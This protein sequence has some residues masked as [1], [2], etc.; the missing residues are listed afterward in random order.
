MLNLKKYFQLALIIFLIVA[1]PRQLFAGSIKGKLQQRLNEESNIQY[2]PYY[3]D[4]NAA[5]NQR[6]EMPMTNV[7]TTRNRIDQS[8]QVM[9]DVVQEV[10]MPNDPYQPALSPFAIYNMNYTAELDENVV[11]VKGK[12]IFE[13]FKKEGWTQ[14]PIVNNSVGLIDVR[15]NKG[16]SF[17][18]NQNG[19]YYLMIDKPGRYNLD[20]EYLI[21]AKREREFGPG[22]FIVDVMPAP[23]SQ[24]EF[25]IPEKSVQVFIEPAIKVEL[26][27]EE[28][29]TIA[30]AVMPNTS[31]ISVRWT[32]AL[33]REEIVPI[34]LEPKAY[35]TTS[36]YSSVGGGVISSQS[37]LNYSILQSEISSFRVALPEDVSVLDVRCNDLRDWKIVKKDGMQVLE[38]FLNFGIKG[39]VQLTLMYER[40]IGEGSQI[41]QMPW[42]RA[43][44]VER[45][46]GFYG[47]AASTNVELAV[48]SS[49]KVTEID[50]KQLPSEIWRSSTNPILLAFKYLN[51]P[52]DIN[53]EVTRHE[54]L[55][56]LIAAIDSADH[57]TLYTNEGKIL[58]KV[59][60][61]VR[62]NVK[63]FLRINLPKD[64]IIWSAFVSGEPVKP[65]KDKTGHIM[66]PLKKSQQSGQNLTQVP[67]QIV[68]LDKSPKMGMLGKLKVQLP[69]VDVPINQFN[70]SI[71]MPDEYSYFNFDGDI[72]KVEN[73][74]RRQR[75]HSIPI[76]GEYMARGVQGRM[77][78]DAD[79]IGDQFSPRQ[80]N[81]EIQR[82][83]EEISTNVAKGILPIQIDVPQEGKLLQFSK[84]LVVEGE[85]PW[86]STQYTAVIEKAKKPIKIF[87]WFLA[88]ILSIIVVKKQRKKKK[89]KL[90]K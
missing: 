63:Q 74:Y 46:S 19:K 69:K 25:I 86:M 39:N 5:R 41:V 23:I 72:K 11:T 73:V 55:P 42:V 48:K 20:V 30:W 79:Q 37:N 51:H 65:A 17:V 54:E 89:E 7:V 4:S 53:I 83:F 38:V 18:V 56:V 21:K 49:D 60:Y 36:T 76:V 61:L 15:V 13:I 31:T 34:K 3:L 71:F 64:S 80:Q 33:T 43:L 6:A 58:T 68:Y 50:T 40:S 70:W 78:S 35:V 9:N 24:F 75:R 57:V 47:V 27:K 16:K 45:E 8:A 66:I 81:M 82:E 90:S 12:V 1:A 22:N 28:D 67:V 87:V 26:T 62:N 59:T 2:E 77:R 44:D 84:L 88:V 29:K 10:L 52:F 32:K 14:L 85:G